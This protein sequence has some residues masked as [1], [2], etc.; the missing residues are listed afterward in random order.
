MGL[1]PFGRR[2]TK[3]KY[4]CRRLYLGDAPE[5]DQMTQA[6]DDVPPWCLTVQ[7]TYTRGKDRGVSLHLPIYPCQDE[8]WRAGIAA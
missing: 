7:V 2:G 6:A 5:G 3:A 8:G 4:L 1:Q